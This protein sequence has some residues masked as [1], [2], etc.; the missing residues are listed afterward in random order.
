VLN[1]VAVSF[2]FSPHA[3][4][5]RRSFQCRWSFQWPSVLPRLSRPQN[6]T[7]IA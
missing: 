6:L 2:F 1:Q 5:C 7:Q 3:P 4:A